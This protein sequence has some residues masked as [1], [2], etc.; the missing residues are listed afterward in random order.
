MIK[1]IIPLLALIFLFPSNADATK[2]YVDFSVAANGNGL[3]S[4][5]SFNNLNSFTNVSRSAGDI[6][7]VRRGTAST[8]NV[9][10]M[11]F[12]SDGL[13][14]NP[15]VI[16]ADYDNIWSDFSTSTQTYTPVFG[17]L[18]MTASAGITGIAAND[19]VYV[20]GDCQEIYNPTTINNCAFAYEV[21]GVSGSTLTL[22]MPYKG[23]QSGAG[24]NLRVMPDNPIVG[25]TATDVV[26]FST[27]LDNFWVIKG[28]DARSTNAACG[29][30]VGRNEGFLMMDMIFQGNGTTDCA[31]QGPTHSH[32]FDKTRFFG[33]L[34]VILTS[35]GGYFYDFLVDCNNVAVSAFINQIAASQG[36]DTY[37]EGGTVQNCVSFTSSGTVTDG[38]GLIARNVKHNNQFL[39][40]DNGFLQQYYYFE[41]S[42][43]IPALNYQSSHVISAQTLPTT[44][45]STT[46]NLRTGGGPVN[47]FVYPASGTG[48]TGLSTKFYPYSYYK[49]FDYPVYA[50]TSS[51]TY[52]M[53]FNSTSTSNFSVDPLTSTATGSTTPELYI[54]CEY[55]NEASGADRFLKRSNTANDVDFNGSTDWQDISVT[56]QPAQAGILHLRGWYAKPKESASNYFYMDTQPEIN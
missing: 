6:A 48:D 40:L 46:D 2:Y 18:T 26:V 22:Y 5:T 42:Y 51:K 44:T 47:L 24:K 16:T 45:Q 15:I 28:L 32:R 12:S 49:L 13:M 34:D 23:A 39:N 25:T 54:E 9:A 36:P 35:R 37:L 19:W 10:S 43:S 4:T 17:A 29:F 52:T 7:Y 38:T 53:Y 14:N 50:D 56:C 21:A 31:I 41:D 30:A 1:Y 27:T 3:A 8:T 20:E 55:Y 11:T 33:M